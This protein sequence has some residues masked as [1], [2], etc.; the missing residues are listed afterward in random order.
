MGSA[1]SVELPNR[2]SVARAQDELRF[3][4]GS[5][6]AVPDYSYPLPVPGEVDIPEIGAVLEAV[7]APAGET[8]SNLENCLDV[9]LLQKTLA[10]RNWR[11]G[12]RYWP[13]HSKSEKKIKELL[14]ERR[15]T[16]DE[17]RL[18]PVVASGDDV[19]WV[20]GFPV[21]SHFRLR[22]VKQVGLVIQE[23]PL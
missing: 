7:L 6:S 12:D 5:T 16:G 1:T 3:G 10:V 18:W 8:V 2:W 17:R 15:V 22:D 4:H 21:A 19:V 23:L 20:R 11:P 13:A 9:S 14:Q